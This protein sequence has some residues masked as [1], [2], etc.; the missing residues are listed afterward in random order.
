M[1]E[2][3]WMGFSLGLAGSVHCMGMCGALQLALPVSQEG[4]LRSGFRVL[5]YQLGRI[6][7]YALLGVAVGVMGKGASWIGVQQFLSVVGGGLLV[8]GAFFPMWLER[9]AV[10]LPVLRRLF[11]WVQRRMRM[12]LYAP[13]LASVFALGALNGL[14]PCGLVYAAL[15]GAITTAEGVQGGLFMAAFGLGTTPLF[16]LLVGSPSALPTVWRRR[17]Q[18]VQPFVLAFVGLWLIWRGLHVDASLFES[19]VPKARLECH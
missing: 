13:G 7:V 9:S 15:A 19:A 5:W 2:W 11:P 12:L 18:R 4:G 10:R 1:G 17:L 14:L 3:L 6:F 8:G 16:L